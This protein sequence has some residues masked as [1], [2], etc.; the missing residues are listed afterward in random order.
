MIC[1]TCYGCCDWWYSRASVNSKTPN[2]E[3]TKSGHGHHHCHHHHHHCA[4]VSFYWRLLLGAF[5]L[6]FPQG[7]HR[8][9]LITEVKSF[10]TDSVDKLNNWI[11]TIEGY[12]RL[13]PTSRPTAAI[14][15]WG[16]NRTQ[17]DSKFHLRVLGF[18]SLI[19][20]MPARV[21]YG[22]PASGADDMNSQKRLVNL[23]VCISVVIRLAR[24]SFCSVSSVN[25][26]ELPVV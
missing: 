6:G 7:K 22:F 12:L 23:V 2:K 11:M 19:Q 15:R 25:W 20:T 14:F 24:C 5:F 8:F 9:F 21:W 16:F 4:L 17:P 10:W 13:P 3:R 18:F 26:S 1:L